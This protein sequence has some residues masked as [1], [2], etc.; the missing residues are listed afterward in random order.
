MKLIH[1]SHS[2]IHKDD[3]TTYAFLEN[4]GRTCYKSEQN[5]KEGSDV[6]FCKAM[7]KN[8]HYAMLEHYWIHIQCKSRVYDQLVRQIQDCFPGEPFPDFFKYLVVSKSRGEHPYTIITGSL[9]AFLELAENKEAARYFTSSCCGYF[10]EL[11]ICALSP[12][13]KIVPSDYGFIPLMFNKDH[14]PDFHVIPEQ[15]LL[16]D[17]RQCSNSLTLEDL[18]KHIS[19]TVRLVCDRGVSHELVRHRPCSFA[20]ES[21]RYCNYSQDKFGNELTFIY[22]SD[23]DKWDKDKQDWFTS[24][25]LDSEIAYIRAI[26]SFGYVPQE[27]RAL[28][29]NAVKTEIVVTASEKEWEH[30]FD[31]RLRGVTGAPHPDIK[32]VMSGIYEDFKLQQKQYIDNL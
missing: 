8:K 1:S 11:L 18:K 26:K 6:S 27:A 13:W 14:L 5:V 22:P 4:I 2:I 24:S 10:S 28:L 17:Y 32:A 21:T 30:I 20:Q 3:F 9:R 23:F 12:F 25:C 16:S 7:V 15:E 31:L 19:H 29:P